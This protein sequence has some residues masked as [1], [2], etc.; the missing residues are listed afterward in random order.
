MIDGLDVLADAGS[1][2]QILRFQRNSLDGDRTSQTSS[3]KSLFKSKEK[4]SRAQ[5]TGQTTS[6]PATELRF[7]ALL[8]GNTL[9]LLS[10][11][12][13]ALAHLEDI[14]ETAEGRL[15]MAVQPLTHSPL[16][17]SDEHRRA[18]QYSAGGLNFLVH[19]AAYA[20]N[21]KY[22]QPFIPVSHSPMEFPGSKIDYHLIPDAMPL[23][24]EHDLLVQCT[25]DGP[26]EKSFAIDEMTF[27]RID[28]LWEVREGSRSNKEPKSLG[29]NEIH[30]DLKKGAA[31]IAPFLRQLREEL[32]VNNS[33][34]VLLQQLDNG[35]VLVVEDIE[36]LSALKEALQTY[37]NPS[38]A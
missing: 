18:I 34:M 14:P 15:K 7:H 27:S 6:Q 19:F 1:L 26:D 11:L 33:P 17:G 16:H 36:P 12:Y 32:S 4:R 20:S 22:S 35:E 2:A 37:Q 13:Q 8:H 29:V 30:T 28:K 38:M 3:S 24:L 31:L 10:D 5:G 25:I 23:P 9:V 21:A